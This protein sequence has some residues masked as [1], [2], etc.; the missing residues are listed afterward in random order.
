MAGRSRRGPSK[1]SHIVNRVDP[2]SVINSLRMTPLA[3]IFRPEESTLFLDI[4][5]DGGALHDLLSDVNCRNRSGDEQPQNHRVRYTPGHF[6]VDDKQVARKLTQNNC[7]GPIRPVSKM[8]FPGLN[9]RL[10]RVN[11][12]RSLRAGDLGI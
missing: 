11:A 7:L 1:L 2:T 12:P 6:S 3:P 10:R 5:P 4:H 8:Q 9:G